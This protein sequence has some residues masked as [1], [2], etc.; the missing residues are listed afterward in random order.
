MRS[1]NAHKTKDLWN[2][3]GNKQ[4][5]SHTH[6]N[7][8]NAQKHLSNWI[9]IWLTLISII[10]IDIVFHTQRLCACVSQWIKNARKCFQTFVDSVFYRFNSKYQVLP[11]ILSSDSVKNLSS[12]TFVTIFKFA[13]GL[14]IAATVTT[15]Q[16]FGQNRWNCD[17]TIH[18][19]IPLWCETVSPVP[20]W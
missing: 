17:A 7:R 6:T 20:I 4:S 10:I 1:I 14:K 16:P 2:D 9:N 3:E 11:A 19:R 5:L 15:Y 8:L 18:I 12:S 13:F